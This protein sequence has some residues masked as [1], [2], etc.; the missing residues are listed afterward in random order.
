MEDGGE[1]LGE[2]VE[3]LVPGSTALTSTCQGLRRG[4][5]VSWGKTKFC[6]DESV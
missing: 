4:E 2:R 3:P 5:G 6:E 1:G